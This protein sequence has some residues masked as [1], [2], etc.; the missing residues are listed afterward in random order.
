MKNTQYLLKTKDSSVIK[1]TVLKE[2]AASL[3][4]MCFFCT[5]KPN[6]AVVSRA[7]L[8]LQI[9]TVKDSTEFIQACSTVHFTVKVA[10]NVTFRMYLM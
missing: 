4:I 7:E 5:A 9:R 3:M 10:Q 1:V 2:F 8:D 6:P